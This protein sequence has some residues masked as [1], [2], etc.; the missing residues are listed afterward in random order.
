[1]QEKTTWEKTK[2]WAKKNPTLTGAIA[3]GT[4]GSVVPGFGTFVG[5]IGGAVVGHLAGRDTKDKDDDK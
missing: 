5:A 2:S 1:M 4:A 3:G